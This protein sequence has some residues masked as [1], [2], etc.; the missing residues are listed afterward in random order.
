MYGPAGVH[1]WGKALLCDLRALA[2]HLWGTEELQGNGGHPQGKAA[3]ERTQVTAPGT[4]LALRK[5]P[6]NA[7]LLPH[8]LPLTFWGHL[9]IA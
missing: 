1:T 4:G 5:Y 8:S 7:Y 9:C 3:S 2:P 6:I